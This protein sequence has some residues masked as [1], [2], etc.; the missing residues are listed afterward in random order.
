[1]NNDTEIEQLS[2]DIL[3]AL[4]NME[5]IFWDV[6][7]GYGQYDE[8]TKRDKYERDDNETLLFEGTK[9]LYYK[10][11]FFFELKNAPI[12]LLVF[13]EKFGKII[14][15]SKKV[16]DSR[17][18]MYMESEPSM[19]ILD[20]FRT[21]LSPFIEFKDSASKRL[22]THHLQLVLEN[23]I[24]ILS[25]TNTTVK[26]ERSIYEVV[27]WYI[28]VIYPQTRRRNNARFIKKFSTYKPDILVPE[29]LSAVEYKYVRTGKNIE[30]FLT[31]L[32]T[33]ADNYTGDSEYK[34]F[35]AV[36]YL[37]DK[38]T[39]NPASYKEAIIEKKFPEN[40]TILIL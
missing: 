29:I 7:V 4:I 3:A 16:T 32:K 40:W 11:C 25:K 10:I 23:T 27:K 28:E 9:E 5:A 31:Q 34:Y 13:T 33:D 36:V 35:F 38:T 18:P 22:V 6:Y 12:Y 26:N 14:S 15:D 20:E 17:A 37:K 39:V 1:M 2:K 8:P 21:F 30:T 24:P 19:I